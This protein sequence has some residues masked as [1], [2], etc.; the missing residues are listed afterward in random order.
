MAFFAGLLTVTT[1]IATTRKSIPSVKDLDGVYILK[2]DDGRTITTLQAWKQRRKAIYAYFADNIY[3]RMPSGKVTV[4]YHLKDKNEIVLNGA[5]TSKT[6][7]LI[8]K[9]DTVERSL[10]VRLWIPNV[11]RK[12]ER[13]APAF[14]SFWDMP[15]DSIIGAGYVAV[16][17][18]ANGLYPDDAMEDKMR[19]RE[20]ESVLALWNIRRDRDLRP[21]TGQ[22]I[23][24]YAWGVSRV[25]DYLETDKDI[26]AS[27]LILTGCS[28][29][30]KA[31]IWT[32]VNEPRLAMIAISQSGGMGAALTQYRGA[33]EE[34][35]SNLAKLFPHWFCPNFYSKFLREE[36]HIR[37]DQDALLALIAPRPLYVCSSVQYKWGDP[38]GEFL[39][40][41]NVA[42]VYHLYG[43]EGLN[44]QYPPAINAPIMNRVGYHDRI[45]P[46]SISTYDW[47]QFFKFAKKWIHHK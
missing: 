37:F 1:G 30:G 38:M 10:T 39:S 43:Y 47:Q 33:D 21:N 13:P 9:R 31:A 2:G 19:N 17:I 14:L 29:A 32:A 35:L 8:F 34:P 23:C 3:G 46:H 25:I 41:R 44:V 22:M 20:A 6:I 42:C 26:D 27:A 11:L 45:G 12:S 28:R 18:M 40:V 5:A 36:D 4:S 15:V 24:C 7:E 16:Q